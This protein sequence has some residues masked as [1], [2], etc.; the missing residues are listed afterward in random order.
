MYKKIWSSKNYF[1]IN[2]YAIGKRNL[3]I[4]R[5]NWENEQD[6]YSNCI[7]LLEQTKRDYHEETYGYYSC[8]ECLINILMKEK[9]LKK[10]I[11]K[12]N[13]FK[14]S[15]DKIFDEEKLFCFGLEGNVI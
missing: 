14:F 4:L 13:G 3:K 8:D 9:Y 15:N 10:W 11:M 12:K 6:Y 1:F 5:R 7:D 2:G